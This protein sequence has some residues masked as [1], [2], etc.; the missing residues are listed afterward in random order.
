MHQALSDNQSIQRRRTWEELPLSSSASFKPSSSHWLLNVSCLLLYLLYPWTSLL[1][2]INIIK[3]LLRWKLWE[4]KK[5]CVFSECN[6]NIEKIELMQA[7]HGYNPF[8]SDNMFPTGDPA[9]MNGQIFTY[10]C[11]FYEQL[12]FVAGYRDFVSVR[13]DLRCDASMA[14]KTYKWGSFCLNVF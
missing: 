13:P 5:K 2:L 1:S 4:R 11:E 9:I 3:T 8:Y 7:M 14:T 10:G 6:P 12:V